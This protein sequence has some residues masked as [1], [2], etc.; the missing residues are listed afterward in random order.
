MVGMTTPHLPE[1]TAPAG[2]LAAAVQ[3]PGR[4]STAVAKEVHGPGL[5][6]VL[7]QASPTVWSW[8]LMMEKPPTRLGHPLGPLGVAANRNDFFA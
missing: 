2:V 8:A 3:P 1:G 4:A 6:A 7:N 5:L